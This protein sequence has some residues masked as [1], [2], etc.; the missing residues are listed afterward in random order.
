M[1]DFAKDFGVIHEAVITGRKLG[2]GRDFWAQ[3]AHFQPMFQR[4]AEE[5]LGRKII[6]VQTNPSNLTLGQLLKKTVEKNG[7]EYASDQKINSLRLEEYRMFGGE[8]LPIHLFNFK[9]DLSGAYA[10]W[11]KM[12]KVGFRPINAHELAWLV[13]KHKKFELELGHRLISFGITMSQERFLCLVQNEQ[14]KLCWST[15]EQNDM[16]GS[17]DFFGALPK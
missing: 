13:I 11:R 15:V 17:T 6:L 16:F 8:T 4:F 7:I 1:S 12:N 9:E 14:G 10:V 3:L 2:L 5:L